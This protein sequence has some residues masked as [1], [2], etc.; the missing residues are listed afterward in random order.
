MDS[1][2][3]NQHNQGEAKPNHLHRQRAA[4]F[5]VIPIQHRTRQPLVD[6]A[7]YQQVLPTRVELDDWATQFPNSGM[8]IVCGRVSR[9]MVLDVDP[10]HGGHLSMKAYPPLARTVWT[11][12]GGWHFYFRVDESF[13]KRLNLLPGV[14]LLGEGSIVYA[15]PTI[16]PSG[17]PYR[18]VGKMLHTVPS[19]VRVLIG[20]RDV[21]LP[22]PAAG[23]LSFHPAPEAPAFL[24]KLRGVK[25]VSGGWMACCPAH[26]DANPSLSIR[27]LADGTPWLKCFAGCDYPLVMMAIED[28]LAEGRP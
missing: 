26:D 9:L 18:W 13:P 1:R 23:S 12:G 21:V 19:W 15:P 28:R 24:T 5:S 16:H 6:W 4:G 3:D 27:V 8:A 7:K 22:L 10:R 20:A 11:G 25:R 14:D 2:K 17:E